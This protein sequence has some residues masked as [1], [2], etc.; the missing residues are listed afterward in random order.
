MLKLISFL[1]LV[2][3]I[4]STLESHHFFSAVNNAKTNFIYAG[5]TLI[6]W[7]LVQFC[8]KKFNFLLQYIFY[9]NFT[10]NRYYCNVFSSKSIPV[11]YLVEKKWREKN[12]PVIQSLVT[13][14]KFRNSSD[15]FKLVP[16]ADPE[17]RSKNGKLSQNY[18]LIIFKWFIIKMHSLLK[19]V[20]L[21]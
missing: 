15:I 11:K 5:S 7:S 6:F 21:V 18:F 3:E 13:R 20:K 4:V 19:Y 1:G 8:F 12:V 2:F 16:A 9:V 14:P 17:K 10:Y